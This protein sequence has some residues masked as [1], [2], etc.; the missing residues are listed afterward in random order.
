MCVYEKHVKIMLNQFTSCLLL[1]SVFS[2]VL[3]IVVFISTEKENVL[4]MNIVTQVTK[5]NICKYCLDHTVFKSTI[6]PFFQPEFSNCSVVI[7]IASIAKAVRRR[8]AIRKTWA[9]YSYFSD[10]QF[11]RLFA[12]GYYTMNYKFIFIYLFNLLLSVIFKFQ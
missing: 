1:F 2:T 12:I 6:R 10:L 3:F 4:S 5:R 8:K 7:V 11:C 9:N